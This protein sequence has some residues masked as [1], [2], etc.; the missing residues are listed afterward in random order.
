MIPEIKTILY[1]TDLSENAQYAFGY[2]VNLANRHDAQIVVLHVIEDI[3]HQMNAQ[4]ADLLGAEKWQ[5]LQRTRKK[6]VVEILVRKIEAFC[7]ETAAANESCPFKAADI[8]VRNGHPVEEIIAE[9]IAS[10]Y[11]VIVMGTHGH[12]IL[13][14][15][16]MGSTAM[17]VVR[18]SH[19]PVMVIRLPK[20]A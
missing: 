9:S 19:V 10:D 12:G 8:K 14:G 11:D 7:L 3:S 4:V 17:R 16:M 2:A 18:R 6:E 1:A 15:A 5:E 13:A 20:T